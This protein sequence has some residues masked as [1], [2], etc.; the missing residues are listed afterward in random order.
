MKL[1]ALVGDRISPV[2]GDV[3]AV[4]IGLLFWG[5]TTG[6]R[7]GGGICGFIWPLLEAFS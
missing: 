4:G 7:G 1:P 5:M 3:I 2:N 6:G